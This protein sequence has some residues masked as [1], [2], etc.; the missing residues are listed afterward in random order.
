MKKTKSLYVLCTLYIK[1]H[2][3]NPADARPVGINRHSVAISSPL[4]D[5]K[6]KKNRLDSGD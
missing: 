6:A 5:F 1:I 4:V 3:S 2:Q